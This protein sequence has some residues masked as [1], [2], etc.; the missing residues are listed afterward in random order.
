MERYGKFHVDDCNI[1]MHLRHNK[2]IVSFTD[3]NCN[4]KSYVAGAQRQMHD[5]SRQNASRTS[6]QQSAI[7]LLCTSE[8]AHGRAIITIGFLPSRPSPQ[9]SQRPSDMGYAWI[10]LRTPVAHA[11]LCVGP[12]T[13]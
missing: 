5:L 12:S 3:C 7:K 10:A 13:L 2:S 4:K 6:D 9:A 8:R 1:A 11:R